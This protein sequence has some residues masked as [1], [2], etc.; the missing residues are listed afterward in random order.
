M[1]TRYRRA[2]CTNPCSPPSSAIICT[3]LWLEYWVRPP[4]PPLLIYSNITIKRPLYNMRSQPSRLFESIICHQSYGHY[5]MMVWFRMTRKNTRGARF[6]NMM[7]I[8]LSC[9]IKLFFYKMM[10]TKEV[11]AYKTTWPGILY[12]TRLLPFCSGNFNED[13]LYI[14]CVFWGFNRIYPWNL[15]DNG[16]WTSTKGDFTSKIWCLLMGMNLLILIK[17]TG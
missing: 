6:Y 14:L 7:G 4:S 12:G 9:S 2:Y 1:A 8:T 11:V 17:K 15:V 5:K 16:D 3:P 10:G 13:V